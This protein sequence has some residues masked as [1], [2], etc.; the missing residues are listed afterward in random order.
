MNLSR[1]TS[2]CWQRCAAQRL[3]ADISPRA[4][5]TALGP[6]DTDAQKA[7]LWDLYASV[8]QTMGSAGGRSWEQGLLDTALHHLAAAY[9]VADNPGAAEGAAAPLASQSCWRPPRDLE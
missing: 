9:G 5:Q 2:G 4:L 6:A 3:A 1:T 8:W 7:R